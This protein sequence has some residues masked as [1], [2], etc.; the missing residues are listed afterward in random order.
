MLLDTDALLWWIDD[1][2]HL[3]EEA[4]EAIGAAESSVAVSA[5][6]AFEIATKC[7]IGKLRFDGDLPAELERHEFEPLPVTIAHGLA[8]GALPMLHRDPFDRILVA[9]ASL[10]RRTF[11]TA[12]AGLARYGIAV[13]A[14]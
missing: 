2:P 4:R 5:V 11:V 13:L 12:D 10:E 6:S 1:S 9:Q 3:G 7:A 8:A 14:T